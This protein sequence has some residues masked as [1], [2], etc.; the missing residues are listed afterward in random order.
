M[1]NTHNKTLEIQNKRGLHA[2]ATAK[3]VKVV[4]DFDDTAIQVT[5]NG[6]TVPGNSIMGLLM[7]G[8]G[9]G[10]TIDVS[11]D[12]PQADAA[13]NAISDLVNDKFGEDKDE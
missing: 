1:S 13:L 5:R 11:A 6:Q 10:T 8:A 9:L 2:R 12:G 3:F 4:A 7:L